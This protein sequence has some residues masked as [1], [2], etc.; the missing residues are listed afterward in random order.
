M[1]SLTRRGE[2]AVLRFSRHGRRFKASLGPISEHAAQRTRLNVE[3]LIATAD[4]GLPPDHDLLCWLKSVGGRL[5]DVLVNAG[6]H[7]ADACWSLGKYLDRH[8]HQTTN[9]RRIVAGELLAL[10]GPDRPLAGLTTRDGRAYWDSLR[11]GENTRRSKVVNARALLRRAIDERWIAGGDPFRDIRTSFQETRTRHAWVGQDMLKA[12]LDQTSDDEFR[13]ILCCS[14]YGGL[15]CP[16]EVLAMQWEDVDWETRR[17]SVRGKG[18]RT[19]TVPLFPPLYEAFQEALLSATVAHGFIVTRNRSERLE[20][21]L[22][23]LMRR[24]GVWWPRPFH[25]MR[26]SRQTELLKEYP[27]HVVCQWL[28]NSPSVAVRHYAQATPD[29]WDAAT[30]AGMMA[31]EATP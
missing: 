6:F 13:L 16:S 22:V 5:Q 26:S 27:I 4:A 15:R 1:A 31:E 30:G 29:D 10:W 19:R 8:G 7:E 11:N 9:R 24:A 25:N 21:I 14:R 17:L 3:R 2:S 28:G 12:V 23:R 20:R 18:R